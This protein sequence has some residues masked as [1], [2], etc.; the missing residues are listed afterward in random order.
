MLKYFTVEKI[1]RNIKDILRKMSREL[2]NIK[3]YVFKPI[4]TFCGNQR[5]V[6]LR[7]AFNSDTIVKVDGP[8]FMVE[9]IYRYFEKGAYINDF[10]R[11]TGGQ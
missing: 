2:G 10:T 9:A 5:V 6:E 8:E 1:D 4:E 7:P 3:L 11:N